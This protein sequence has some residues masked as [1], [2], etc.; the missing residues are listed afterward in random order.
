MR[1]YKKALFTIEGFGGNYEGFTCE[2]YWNG[3]ECPYFAKDIVDKQLVPAII[4]NGEN[5]DF[6]AKVEYISEKDS[7]RVWLDVYDS[8]YYEDFGGMDIEYN[9]ETIHVYSIGGGSWVWELVEEEENN[10]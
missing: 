7:Y 6:P 5:I 10:D 4:K 8:D 1:E 2:Q 3:W 9:G